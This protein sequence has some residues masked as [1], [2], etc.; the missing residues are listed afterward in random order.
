MWALVLAFALFAVVV[1]SA[2]ATSSNAVQSSVTA[3]DVATCGGVS[4]VAVTLQAQDPPAVSA[5]LDVM[6]VLDESGSIAASDF[7]KEKA[8]VQNLA[9]SFVFGPQ[10][11]S[12]GV[13]QFSGNAR[14][15]V[16]LPTTNKASFV[17]AV[18]ALYQRGGS[19]AIGDGLQQ[20]QQEFA[21]RGRHTVKQVYILLTDG[22]NN[23][24]TG[25][26]PG[27]V[28]SLHADPR[29][30]VY[31]IGVGA[32]VDADELRT[33]AG[34]NGTAYTSVPDFNALNGLIAPLM[35]QLNPAASNL[36]YRVSPAAGWEFVPGSATATQG[37]VAATSDGF[38]WSL[39]A[40]HT[41]TMG[42]HYRLR[43]TGATGGNLTPQAV[44]D[45]S[46]TDGTGGAQTQ[47]LAG[48]TVTVAGCN[49]APVAHASAPALV[50]LAGS[51]LAP[52]QLNGAG[53]TDDGQ[54][55]PLSYTWSENG[56]T[57]S[58]DESPT[59]DLGLGSHV[60]TL[61]VSDGQYQATDSV[62]VTVDDPTP[63]VITPHVAGTTGTGGWLTSD[64]VVSFDVS[65]LESDV[66]PGAGCSGTTVSADTAGTTFTCSA[67]SAGGTATATVTVR[68]DGT[69][70]V[71]TYTPSAATYGVDDVV[72]IGCTV[73]DATS[74]VAGN[75]TCPGAVGAAYT[76]A[77]GHH[78]LTY[79]ATDNAGNIGTGTATFT[80]V[81]APADVCTLVRR[82]TD[83]AGVASSLCTKLKNGSTRAFT[84]EVNAQ[85]GKHLQADKA[86]VLIRL[87]NAL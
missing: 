55:Q 1:G 13:V 81:V 70:P 47:S 4:D 17:N 8:F 65:D 84:N 85:R 59:V 9:N 83:N 40:L 14:V 43:H 38:A 34:S 76:F 35:Q 74:G 57:I 49:Q 36:S 11:V 26:F 2:G 37:A 25:Q 10:A 45:L 79:S 72:S 75:A 22:F 24:S 61:T 64:A 48:Q 62:T 80:I 60:I 63:P 12:A 33:I 15:S 32:F 29:N 69:A 42:L 53:S 39:A 7:Q 44:A 73:S 87:A 30:V 52:V 77:A 18:S 19:T 28:A 16:Q 41:G 23:V 31:A 6:F 21:A 82:W 71:V 58:T 46:W 27:V 86:A 56:V 67:G 50:H 54:I 20:A 5:P 68:R 78:T 51:R 66:T 3:T